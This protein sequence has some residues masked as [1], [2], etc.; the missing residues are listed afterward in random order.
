MGLLLH[1]RHTSPAPGATDHPGRRRPPAAAWCPRRR[2][3]RSALVCLSGTSSPSSLLSSLALGGTHLLS[4]EL[5]LGD[6][7]PLALHVLEQT[8][9]HDAA[10]EAVQQLLKALVVSRYDLHLN[11]FLTP[12]SQLE[13]QGTL[14]RWRAYSA[15]CSLLPNHSILRRW[16]RD[17]SR[18]ANRMSGSSPG[19]PRGSFHTV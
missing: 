13:E 7:V 12:A 3:Y 6:E 2:R 4:A 19:T 5:A 1:I 10:L 8:L 18:P 9:F 16:I 15:R 11:P 17:K 14:L